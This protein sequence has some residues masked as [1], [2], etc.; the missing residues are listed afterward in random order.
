M[1]MFMCTCLLMFVYS[2][3]YV[4]DCVHVNAYAYIFLCMFMF[5]S[6]S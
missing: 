3:E 6:M 2:F 4:D 5:F 1:R